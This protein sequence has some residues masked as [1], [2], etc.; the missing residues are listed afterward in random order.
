MG[1]KS[2]ILP[3]VKMKIIEEYL[4]GR[5]GVT[6]AATKLGVSVS[7]IKG[8]IRKYKAFGP[9]GLITNSKNN[10]YHPSLKLQAIT[11]YMI[12][13]GSLSDICMQY[14]IRTV[15]ILHNWIKQYNNS[16]KVSRSHNRKGDKIMTNGRK[17]TYEE[18]VE[19]VSFCIANAND[20]SL[21]ANKYNVS[22]QQVYT[23]V[24][25]YAKEGYDALV[26][27]R[28][29]HKT[30]EE[31]S[32]SDRIAIQLKLLEAENRSLKMENDF[33]KKLQ[34]IERR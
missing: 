1:R 33:L 19:I 32:E 30:L 22:Y 18:R 27:R 16:H 7:G 34:E 15:G 23:W 29:K 4:E 25:K 14:G 28:G 21:T 6:K 26:D 12:G 2:N 5:I 9:E 24:K 8:W 11:D 3:E 20:Y 17:T 13:N 10:Y 31:P